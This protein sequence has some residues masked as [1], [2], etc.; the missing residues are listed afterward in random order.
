[1]KLEEMIES[2][3][4]E[5]ELPEQA[6]SKID[7]DMEQMGKL[8][9]AIRMIKSL[10]DECECEPSEMFEHGLSDDQGEEES[11]PEMG[12]GKGKMALIIAQMKAKKGE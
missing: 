1:M 11:S 10:A 12:P 6:E 8:K 5:K 4:S 2:Q 9:E 3:G 7:L